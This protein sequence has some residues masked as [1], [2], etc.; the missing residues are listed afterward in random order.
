MNLQVGVPEDS[1]LKKK[2]PK[3]TSAPVQR[4][5]GFGNLRFPTGKRI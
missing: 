4:K 2:T 3:S 5:D 1:H